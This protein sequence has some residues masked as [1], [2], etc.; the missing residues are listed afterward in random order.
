MKTYHMNK[1]ERQITDQA[2]LFAIVTR[3]KYAVISL[4]RDNEPYL[5]TLNYGFDAE[6]KALYFHT[7]Q[8]GLKM[9]FIKQNPRVCGTIIEDR[10]YLMNQCSHSY[11]SA[12]FFG[13]L[14]IVPDMAEMKHGMEIML[15]HLE[16]TPDKVREKFLQDDQVYQKRHLVILRLDIEEITGKQG[17]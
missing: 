4:C 6:K 17:K 7:A 1:K 10:G 14:Q 16:E 5:V 2:A 11:R 15:H 13:T 3:G 12:V 8:E 9:D